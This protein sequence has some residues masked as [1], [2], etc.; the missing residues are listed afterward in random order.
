MHFRFALLVVITTATLTPQQTKTVKKV[1]DSLVAPCCYEQSIALHM[2]DV[3]EKMRHEV[4]Q[5]VADGMT[6]QQILDHY[7]AI[8]GERIL[9]VPDGVAGQVSYFF[10][11]LF[12]VAGVGLILIV[13]RRALLPRTTAMPAAQRPTPEPSQE[14]IVQKIRAE[15]EEEY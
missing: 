1:E 4:T 14:L 7:K 15:L 6:E 10:P 9:I 8:Y 12:S 2:S 5:M 3:A 13:L 11:V